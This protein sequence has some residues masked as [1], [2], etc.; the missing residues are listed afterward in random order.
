MV[1]EGAAK[2]HMHH[3][4]H[5]GVSASKIMKVLSAKRESNP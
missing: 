5:V 4:M 2:Y 3:Q 1:K